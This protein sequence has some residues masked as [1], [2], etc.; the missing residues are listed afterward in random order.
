MP[1]MKDPKDVCK[2]CRSSQVG[3]LCMSAPTQGS[4]N[5]LLAMSLKISIRKSLFIISFLT[6]LCLQ[7]VQLFE[8]PRHKLVPRQILQGPDPRRNGDHKDNEQARDPVRCGKSWGTANPQTQK[9]W[10]SCRSFTNLTYYC[11]QAECY[12]ENPATN[13]NSPPASTIE[14][15]ECVKFAAAPVPI[16][17]ITPVSYLAHNDHG[18][19]IV[20]GLRPGSVDPELYIC[21]WDSDKD[22]NF[23]RPWCQK[24]LF[25]LWPEPNWK[26]G[27]IVNTPKIITKT[28]SSI[29]PHKI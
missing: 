3:K 17:S 16:P 23:Q 29:F 9:G 27:I 6:T 13:R 15:K 2:K 5:S 10:V 4:R 1:L 14:L 18:T 28:Y 21:R 8:L 25:W 26:Y 7:L 11:P 19:M 22:P 20:K 24:C 12:K